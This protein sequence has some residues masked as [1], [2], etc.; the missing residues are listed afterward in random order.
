M[1]VIGCS[2]CCHVGV[3]LVF[4]AS[5]AVV[6][7]AGALPAVSVFVVIDGPAVYAGRFFWFTEEFRG[8]GN[9][10][11]CCASLWFAYG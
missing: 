2:P 8:G 5:L 6:A 4:Y 10:E 7:L 1:A 9:H 11:Y 3:I